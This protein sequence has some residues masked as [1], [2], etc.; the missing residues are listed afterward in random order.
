MGA[1]ATG[2]QTVRAAGARRSKTTTL[3]ESIWEDDLRAGG[4]C[5]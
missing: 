5:G 3:L 2:A 1:R 4:M